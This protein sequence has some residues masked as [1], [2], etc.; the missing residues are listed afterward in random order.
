MLSNSTTKSDANA[1]SEM[2]NTQN[3]SHRLSRVIK[4]C[5]V[6][7]VYLQV[8]HSSYYFK[9]N[10]IMTVVAEIFYGTIS[11]SAVH[12]YECNAVP[13]FLLGFTTLI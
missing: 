5:L 7:I 10:E 12:T 6:E 13:Q 1:S 11:C 2:F 8:C 9:K 4:Q 3:Y